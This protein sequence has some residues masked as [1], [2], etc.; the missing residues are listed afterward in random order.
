MPP[1]FKSLLSA[2]SQKKFKASVLVLIPAPFL[3]PPPASVELSHTP[4][5]IR[6][7]LLTWAPPL[8]SEEHKSTIVVQDA[9]KKEVALARD[10]MDKARTEKDKNLMD[11]AKLQQ[12]A[13][14][15]LA[16]LQE[17]GTPPKHSAWVVTKPPANLLD[18]PEPYS[19]IL[20]L[21]FNE[22]EY[23]NQPLEKNEVDDEAEV[24]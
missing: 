16:C 9:A 19:S 8:F 14:G 21:G 3:A 23:D 24:E 17:L 7:R 4:K 10:V 5:K 13:Q 20:H 2:P 22:K 1:K 15:W 18:S 12:V 6:G 11:L